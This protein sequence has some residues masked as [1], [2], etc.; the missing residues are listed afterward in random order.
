MDFENVVTIDVLLPKVSFSKITVLNLCILEA[1]LPEAV[2]LL[3]FK[4]LQ[5]YF[6]FCILNL[7]GTLNFVGSS[8]FMFYNTSN[9]KQL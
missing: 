9:Q 6:I 1:K 3:Y 2:Y 7:F 5:Y 4:V 8:R